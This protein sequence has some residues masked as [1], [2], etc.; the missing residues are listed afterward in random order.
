MAGRGGCFGSSAGF[1][2]GSGCG[3]VFGG[4]IMEDGGVIGKGNCNVV[5]DIITS[6]LAALY[7]SRSSVEE[8]ILAACSRCCRVS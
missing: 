1:G 5:G 7:H 3:S 4:V 2:G 6:F 8:R